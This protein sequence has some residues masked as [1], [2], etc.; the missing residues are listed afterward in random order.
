MSNPNLFHTH[1]GKF[2][3][4]KQVRLHL[5]DCWV[6]YACHTNMHLCN[7]TPQAWPHRFLLCSSTSVSI[8]SQCVNPVFYAEASL[9]SNGDH[10]NTVHGF[11]TL[12][13]QP[14]PE[15][16]EECER[17]EE[18]NKGHYVESVHNL[19]SKS[20]SAVKQIILIVACV[21]LTCS[22][23]ILAAAALGVCAATVLSSD[24][25]G[26]LP[27]LPTEKRGVKGD[28]K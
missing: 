21:C 24:T 13:A 20:L 18:F 17:G 23:S 28:N 9:Q 25:G 6:S 7:S 8:N 4:K 3:L 26:P 10:R 19:G 1:S 5:S 11:S 15:E 27:L 2:S 14:H 16:Q 12:P 22:C